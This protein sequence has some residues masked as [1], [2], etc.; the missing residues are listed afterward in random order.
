MKKRWKKLL[1]RFTKFFSPRN[2]Q[3]PKRICRACL[4]PIKRHHKYF[5]EGGS[6]QHKDCAIPTGQIE[7]SAQQELI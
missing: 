1:R 5:F 2:D 6:V 7:P 4:R 3:K